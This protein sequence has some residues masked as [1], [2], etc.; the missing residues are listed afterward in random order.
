MS[1]SVLLLS[2][3]EILQNPIDILRLSLQNVDI[4]FRMIPLNLSLSPALPCQSQKEAVQHRC[5]VLPLLQINKDK[6]PWLAKGQ[7]SLQK[8]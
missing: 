8:S 6:H 7:S 4:Y 1:L 2:G 5:S 3:L